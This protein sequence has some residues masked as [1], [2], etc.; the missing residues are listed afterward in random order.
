MYA[1]GGRPIQ[2]TLRHS[3]YALRCKLAPNVILNFD[4]AEGQQVRATGHLS[5]SSQSARFH[6]RVHDLEALRVDSEQPAPELTPMPAKAVRSV[7]PDWLKNIKQRAQSAPRGMI[8][9]EIPDWVH[10]LAPPDAHLPPPSLPAGNVQWGAQR[11]QAIL[12]PVT[13][14]DEAIYQ[15]PTGVSRLEDNERLLAFLLEALERSEHEDVELTGQVLAQF[16]PP[17]PVAEDQSE[18]TTPPFPQAEPHST[19]APGAS[20]PTLVTHLSQQLWFPH[21][22][23]I[24]GALLIV[25]F[26]LLAFRV[27]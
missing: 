9:A 21:L 4:L 2:F 1:S 11:A 13:L 25:L 16:I 8:P 19:V 6:L 23:L 7:V 17:P 14:T 15:A 12:E 10:A 27:I 26:L 22:L 24:A 20:I 5:F 18:Q 3:G